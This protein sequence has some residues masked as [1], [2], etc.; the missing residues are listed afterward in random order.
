M[1]VAIEAKRI[2]QEALDRNREK[3]ALEQR[4]QLV[5]YEQERALELERED[6]TI[7]DAREKVKGLQDDYCAYKN[8][9][10]GAEARLCGLTRTGSPNTG[11]SPSGDRSSA[12]PAS[13]TLPADS[14]E[15]SSH[16]KTMGAEFSEFRQLR[17]SHPDMSV[18]EFSGFKLYFDEKQTA[19]RRRDGMNRP[20]RARPPPESAR[21][22]GPRRNITYHHH[23][24]E[25]QHRG[26]DSRE[27]HLRDRPSTGP[28]W[29]EKNGSPLLALSSLTKIRTSQSQA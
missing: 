28:R 6:M 11:H 25:R 26:R 10:A 5:R 8:R 21:S 22:E 19:A 17:K 2:T 1:G 23:R 4:Q 29:E 9:K 14:K 18:Q 12:A 24:V 3:L 15:E 7:R 16:L 13:S 20:G 27:R